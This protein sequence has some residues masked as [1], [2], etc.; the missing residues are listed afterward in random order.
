MLNLAVKHIGDGLYPAMR[1][2][3]KTFDILVRIAGMKVI[4]QQKGVQIRELLVAK[5]PFQVHASPFDGRL[6]FQYSFNFSDISHFVPQI[7]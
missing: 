3:R 4:Q 6:T 1:M 7:I 5:R 2:P